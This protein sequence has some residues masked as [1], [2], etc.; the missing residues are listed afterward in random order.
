MRRRVTFGLA[1]FVLRTILIVGVA[2]GIQYFYR[3]SQE[4]NSAAK[5][6]PAPVFLEDP[7]SY[8]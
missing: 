5:A 2:L 6:S 1:G 7:E 4:P 3:A 8:P